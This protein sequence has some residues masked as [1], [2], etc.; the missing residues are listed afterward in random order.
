MD[1][2]QLERIIIDSRSSTVR[3]Y[4]EVFRSSGATVGEV[5]RDI[6]VIEPE[7][8]CHPERAIGARQW[9]PIYLQIAHGGASATNFYAQ[10][11]AYRAFATESSIACGANG[12]FLCSVP[13][14][15]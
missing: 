9:N 14:L 6:L 7:L 8:V 5:D 4:R 12:S 13:P 3:I 11:K 1:F 2:P 15:T 10:R